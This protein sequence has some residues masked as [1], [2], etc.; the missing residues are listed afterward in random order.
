V[1]WTVQA[2]G[3]ADYFMKVTGHVARERDVGNYKWIR[4]RGRLLGE[5]QIRKAVYPVSY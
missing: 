4:F 2:F 1:A 3:K 5:S